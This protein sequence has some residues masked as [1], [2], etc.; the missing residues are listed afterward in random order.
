MESG[1]LGLVAVVAGVVAE[2][3]RQWSLV[4]VETAHII[5]YYK[6]AAL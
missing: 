3:P 5:A 2:R 4:E 6:S 1:L